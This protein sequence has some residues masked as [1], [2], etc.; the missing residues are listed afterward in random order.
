MPVTHRDI[1][2]VIREEP[3]MRPRILAA[4]ADEDGG[5]TIRLAITCASPYALRTRGVVYAIEGTGSTAQREKR[6]VGDRGLE[7]LTFTI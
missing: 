7:P 4:L 5:P 6:M 2:E 1:R 3:V